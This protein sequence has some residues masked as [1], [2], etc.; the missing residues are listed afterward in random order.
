MT[1]SKPSSHSTGRLNR[2][3]RPVKLP[4]VMWPPPGRLDHP[5]WPPYKIFSENCRTTLDTFH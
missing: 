2:L 5:M 3:H 1:K 4:L